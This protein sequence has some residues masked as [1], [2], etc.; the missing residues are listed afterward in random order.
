MAILI[1]EHCKQEFKCTKR[2]KTR[3]YCSKRCL[4][5]ARHAKRGHAHKPVV[6]PTCGKTVMMRGSLASVQKFCSR[7]CWRN[8]ETKWP[9][10]FNCEFCDKLV[11]RVRTSH[12]RPG[13]AQF[14]SVQCRSEAKRKNQTVTN[15]GYRVHSVKGKPVLEHRIIMEK[16]LGRPLRKDENVHH[17][18]GQ[19][20]DNREDNLEL[21]SQ[22]QP[23]GQCVA[24]KIS[25]AIEFLKEYGYQV[26][27]PVVA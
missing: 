13:R 25:W 23:P 4:A 3:R 21:W 2:V 5:F 22:A 7:E 18:N 8:R 24:D 20:L 11:D 27:P 12:Y 9:R 26:T 17:R 15:Q 1:C 6:C 16:I 10:T 14:C 19:R